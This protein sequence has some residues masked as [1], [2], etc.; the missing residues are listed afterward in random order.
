MSWGGTSISVSNISL[1]I[2]NNLGDDRR[3]LGSRLRDR[4]VRNSWLEVRGTF[5]AEFDS[6]TLYTDFRAATQRQL[7]ATWTGPNIGG[8]VNHE[9][10]VT[11]PVGL[12]VEGAQPVVGG[13]GRVTVDIGFRAY[14]DATNSE[15]KIDVT[16]TSVSSD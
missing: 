14:R 2:L 12:I 15:I 6:T 13:A 16:N 8:S 10:K 3:F 1:A 4:A 5:Q 7:I 11:C 9:L